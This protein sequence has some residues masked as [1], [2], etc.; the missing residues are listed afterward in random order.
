M[1]EVG[2]KYAATL[3]EEGFEALWNE[4]EFKD[5]REV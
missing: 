4:S 1:I 5:M 3:S 2:K